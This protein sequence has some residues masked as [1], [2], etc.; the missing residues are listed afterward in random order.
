MPRTSQADDGFTLLEVLVTVSV[1][2][3]MVGAMA[4]L[5]WQPRSGV[6]ELERA[7][8]R[9]L[10]HAREQAILNNVPVGVVFDLEARRFGVDALDQRFP[11]TLQLSLE[12]A[13]EA[14]VQQGQPRIVFVADGSSTGGT[15]TL[16]DGRT[17]RTIAV[18]WLTGAIRRD[19]D[20]AD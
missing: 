6:A 7:L 19:A 12:T 1:L 11:E 20:M 3:L 5:S 10:S 15:V 18:H 2:A 14:A 4:S 8:V 13:S 16:D 9:T 17:S